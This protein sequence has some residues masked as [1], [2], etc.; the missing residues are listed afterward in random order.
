MQVYLLLEVIGRDFLGHGTADPVPANLN[1]ILVQVVVQ[2]LGLDP[3]LDLS[4][5][6][7]LDLDLY[8]D[9]DRFHDLLPVFVCHTKVNSK[10]M[11]PG[12]L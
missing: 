12:I 2:K 6:L 8:F 5:N 1:D 9:H 4:I 7:D 11:E 10:A 3:A